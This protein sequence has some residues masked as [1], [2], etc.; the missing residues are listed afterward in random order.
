MAKTTTRRSAAVNRAHLSE[1]ILH[2]GTNGYRRW[3]TPGL[4]ERFVRQELPPEL[5]ILKAPPVAGKNYNCFMYALGLHTS[6]QVL[7]ESKGFIYGAFFQR[8]LNEGLLEPTKQPKKGDMILYRKPGHF[9][10]EFTHAGVVTNAEYITS[11]WAWGPLI[12]HRLFDVPSF[13]GS[14][15]VYVKKISPARA[16]KLWEEHR[17]FSKIGE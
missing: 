15:I 10:D 7:K 16:K 17:A 12:Q 9:G 11:K 14:S 5:K 13:Y 4:F 1:L 6:K 2:S 8:L 3:Y